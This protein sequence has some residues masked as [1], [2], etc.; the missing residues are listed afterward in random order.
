MLPRIRQEEARRAA[1]VLGIG[2]QWFLNER[3][4]HFTLN[5]KEVLEKTWNTDRVENWLVQ[6]LRKS[7]YDVVIVLLPTEDTQGEHKAAS[8]LA[9]R[10]VEQ[11]PDN[12][13]PTV[14]G[15]QASPKDTVSYEALSGFPITAV[16]SAQP[17]FHFDRDEHFGFRDSLSYQIVADWVIAEHKSQGL[18][19]TTVGQNRYENFWVFS[20][21]GNTANK[22][23]SEFFENKSPKPQGVERIGEAASAK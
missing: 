17:Q 2:H 22:T 6:R 7:R 11:L 18:F 16:N 8:I 23:A 21:G 1:R 4:D 19:Q 10:A 13:R 12:Q 15:V 9:L 20:N 14:L 3:E 5:V